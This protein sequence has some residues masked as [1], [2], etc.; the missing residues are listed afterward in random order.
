MYEELVLTIGFALILL[1]YVS[2][3][4]FQARFHREIVS[5]YPTVVERVVLSALMV[6]VLLRTKW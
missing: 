3:R 4:A 6:M 5:A 1:I 2:T